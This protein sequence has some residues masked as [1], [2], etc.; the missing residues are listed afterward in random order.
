MAVITISGQF[1]SGAEILSQMLAKELG[2][3]LVDDYIIQMIAKE[4]NVSPNFV[5]LVEGQGGSKL[6]R[7]ISTLVSKSKIEHILGDDSGYIDDVTYID[8]LI[9]LISQLADEGN[10]VIQGRG[11]QYILKGHPD[12]FHILIINE[13][14]NRVKYLVEFSKMSEKRAI[15]TVHNEDKR[16]DNLYGKLGKKDYDEASL[17]H[18]VLNIGKLTTDKALKQILYIMS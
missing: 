15:T 16:R 18:L 17:Y 11:S 3:T 1:C 8:Y 6:S 2:Y 7:F 9:L 10:A 5:K 14:E 4:A 12:T 13:F